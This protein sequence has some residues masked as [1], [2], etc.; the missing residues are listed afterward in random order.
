MYQIEE[1]TYFIYLAIIPV[2]FVLFLLVL[3]WKRRTQKQFADSDLIQ[4]LS[5]Q[6]STFKSFLKITAICLGLGFLIIS[7]T[8]SN[9]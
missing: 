6:K 3:W 9:N 1:P 5:P 7:L 2:I 4:K 8:F